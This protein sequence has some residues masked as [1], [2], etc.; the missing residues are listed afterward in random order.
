[1]A[2]QELSLGDAL[3]RYLDHSSLKPGLLDARLKE[4]WEKLMGKTIAR[5]TDSVE[6]RD[7]K[8]IIHTTV[9]SLRHELNFSREKIIRLINAA[10][11]EEVIRDISVR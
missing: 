4:D 5:Y 10:F 11:G 8:L 1:M 6:I 9:S 3:Q 7:K 2:H